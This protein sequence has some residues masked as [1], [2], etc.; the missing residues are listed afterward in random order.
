MQKDDDGN[1]PEERWLLMTNRAFAS[2]LQEGAGPF[3]FWRDDGSDSDEQRLWTNCA[4]WL[5]IVPTTFKVGILVVLVVAYA[6]SVTV[7]AAGYFATDILQHVETRASAI[8]VM[9]GVGGVWD[10]EG[11]W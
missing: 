2:S 4:D 3:R 5:I 7:F 8:V 10:E 6:W 1:G 9:M 11:V